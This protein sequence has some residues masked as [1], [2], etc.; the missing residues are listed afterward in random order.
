MWIEK[1]HPLAYYNTGM[2]LFAFGAYRSLI[3][4]DIKRL[5]G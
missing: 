3:G 5:S 4:R 2:T 1:A